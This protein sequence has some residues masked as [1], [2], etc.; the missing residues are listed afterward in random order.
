[1]VRLVA[2]IAPIRVCSSSGTPRLAERGTTCQS[3]GG[4][5][6]G[7]FVACLPY[8]ILARCMCSVVCYYYIN[9]ARQDTHYM[10]HWVGSAGSIPILVFIFSVLLLRIIQKGHNK[11][12]NVRSVPNK[13][14]CVTLCRLC[15][16]HYLTNRASTTPSNILRVVRGCQSIR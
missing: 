8:Y 16:S 10:L 6:S 4:R 3:K 14:E 9:T 12:S 1:M 15:S 11:T 2:L 13:N 7:N 5:G